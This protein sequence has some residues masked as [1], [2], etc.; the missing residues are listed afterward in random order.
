[1]PVARLIASLNPGDAALRYFPIPLTPLVPEVLSGEGL[2]PHY[3]RLA[4]SCLC[5]SGII[6]VEVAVVTTRLEADPLAVEVQI[7]ETGFDA[8]IILNSPL[9]RQ[10]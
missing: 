5:H 2:V 9:P 4:Y 3:S 8:D 10:Y 7:T 1:M 6:A